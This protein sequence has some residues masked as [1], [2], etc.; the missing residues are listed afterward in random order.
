MTFLDKL[1]EHHQNLRTK[2]NSQLEEEQKSKVK[3]KRAR[4]T[5]YDY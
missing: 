2:W 5:I 1:A 4:K 3:Q